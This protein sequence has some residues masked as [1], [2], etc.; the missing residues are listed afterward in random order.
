MILLFQLQFRHFKND[1]VFGAQFE[2]LKNVFNLA[3]NA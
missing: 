1:C 2:E 3:V